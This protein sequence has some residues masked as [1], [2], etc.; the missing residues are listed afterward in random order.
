M[1]PL[2]D[3]IVCTEDHKAVLVGVNVE[4]PAQKSG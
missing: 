2:F 1:L 4:L 3:Q